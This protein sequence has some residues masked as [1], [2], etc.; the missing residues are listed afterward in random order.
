MKIDPKTGKP[1]LEFFRVDEGGWIEIAPGIKQKI[2]A[3]GLDEANKRGFLNRL[4]ALG[5]GRDDRRSDRA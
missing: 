1:H 2:L 3:G 4:G 5:T